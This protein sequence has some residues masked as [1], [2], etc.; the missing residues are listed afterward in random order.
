MCW[1]TKPR[2]DRVLR[3]VDMEEKAAG[4]RGRP[5]LFDEDE[6]LDAAIALFWQFG[7][8]H[9]T[10]RDLEAAL[11]MRQPSIQNA[12]GSKSDLL[13]RAMDKYEATVDRELFAV[14]V[15]DGDGYRAIRVFLDKLDAWMEGSGYHGCLMVNLMN[16]RPDDDV[17][18]DR[19]RAFRTKV[20]NGL[21]AAIGRSETDTDLV[22]SRASVLQAAVLGL[23]AAAVSADSRDEVKAMFVGVHELVSSWDRIVAA[24]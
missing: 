17:V 20:F 16:D 11:N 1:P 2:S 21:A 15:E 14:L 19:V 5:R 24:G 6:A 7:Y 9:T 13:L 18:V 10:T 3:F 23:L 22:A 8:R 12:F 4:P